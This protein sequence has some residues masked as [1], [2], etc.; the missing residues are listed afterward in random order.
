M[1]VTT[2]N[3]VEGQEISQ[4]VTIV[5]GDK[6]VDTSCFSDPNSDDPEV[7]GERGVQRARDIALQDMRHRAEDLGVNAVVGVTVD[8]RMVRPDNRVV[9]VT[10]TGTAV[11][12][13]FDS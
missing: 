1:I 3:S 7:S 2:T 4:Y 13:R 6:V 11:R 9:L 5:V 10:A 12:L 8:H